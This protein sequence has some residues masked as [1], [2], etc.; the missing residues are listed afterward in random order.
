MSGLYRRL[1]ADPRLD[2]RL[3]V[4]GA[5]LSK[6]YGYSLD[7]SSMPTEYQVL[8]SIKSLI[9]SDSISSRLKSASI[10]LQSAVDIVAAWRPDLILYAGDREEVLEFRSSAR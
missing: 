1:A 3:I 10:M 7:C 6:T 4:G 2:F 5:H 8:A 9:D